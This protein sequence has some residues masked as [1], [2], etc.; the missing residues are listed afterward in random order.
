MTKEEKE[1]LYTLRWHVRE[2]WGTESGKEKSLEI[3]GSLLDPEAQPEARPSSSG[4]EQ[5]LLWCPFALNNFPKAPTKGSY[6]KGYPEGAIVHFTAGRY[7]DLADSLSS[8]IKNGYTYFVIDQDGNIGQNFPLDSWGYHA[9][10]SKWQGLGESVSSKLVGIEVQCA[11]KVKPK[12]TKYETWFGSIIEQEQVRHIAQNTANQQEAGH[13]HKYTS[14]QEGALKRLI[15]WLHRNNSEVFSLDYVLG[16]DE[17][18]GP[19]GIGKWRKNDPGGS[20]SKTM[21]DFRIEL[22]A[23]VEN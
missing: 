8:Q 9:G 2:K 11:G 14:A 17:V 18:S 10:E 5:H 13:Y 6:R 15:L 4:S 22:K 16:H 19:K 3:L 21:D 1:S 7:H 20:L 23:D 12:G